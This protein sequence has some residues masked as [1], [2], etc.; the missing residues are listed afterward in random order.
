[1]TSTL[2]TLGM[3]SWLFA[4]V[5]MAT[6][7]ELPCHIHAPAGKESLIGNP[8]PKKHKSRSECEIAND[9]YFG[10]LGRCH[11]GNDALRKKPFDPFLGA[12]GFRNE[13]SW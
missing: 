6:N 12:P 1:M 7:K 4:S 9:Q 8:V 2:L 11:C 13:G 10:R 5:A 3:L